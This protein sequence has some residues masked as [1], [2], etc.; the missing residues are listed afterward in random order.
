MARQLN[1]QALEPAAL[2]NEK[3]IEEKANQIRIAIDAYK[4]DHGP[5]LDLDFF[6][7]K[8]RLPMLY[9]KNNR[10]DR[11]LAAYKAL[12]E[13][14]N[15]FFEQEVLTSGTAPL[16]GHLLAVANLNYARCLWHEGSRQSLDHAALISKKG[17]TDIGN[18]AGRDTGDGA[19]LCA[20]TGLV[21]LRLD[22]KDWAQ[23]FL[24]GFNRFI[25]TKGIVLERA[26]QDAVLLSD[27][28]DQYV[29]LGDI[30]KA[31]ENFKLAKKA[32]ALLGDEGQYNLAVTNQRLADLAAHEH[33]YFEATTLYDS[34]AESLSSLRGENST[35]RAKILFSEADVLWK[36]NQ[37]GKAWSVRCE[38]IRIW[39][40]P[41]NS[42]RRTQSNRP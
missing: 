31:S 42:E 23:E 37:F 41:F 25:D 38:A 11:A 18:S 12:C 36:S 28:G 39:N 26:D 22:A 3:E 33:D 1:W 19:H 14:G 9:Y 35:A 7:L 6:E 13:E 27:I 40:N 21:G 17:L 30:H 32:W 8:S 16:I 5:K 20:M 34:A 15:K 2:L 24:N 29:R 4:I 10:F